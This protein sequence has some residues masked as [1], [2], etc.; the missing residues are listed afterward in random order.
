MF[1]KITPVH[2]LS[3]H[4]TLPGLRA[5]S[6]RGDRKTYNPCHRPRTLHGHQELILSRVIYFHHHTSQ[7]SQGKP[8][9]DSE[10]DTHVHV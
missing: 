2:R 1:Q 10:G 4:G 6:P 5:N 3:C 8:A 9:H 7:S